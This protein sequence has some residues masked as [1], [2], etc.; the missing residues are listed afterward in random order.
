M[1]IIEV[2]FFGAFQSRTIEKLRGGGTAMT[3]FII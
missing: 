3:I 2:S 1:T